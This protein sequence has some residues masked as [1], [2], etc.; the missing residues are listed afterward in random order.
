MAACSISIVVNPGLV[1][2]LYIIVLVEIISWP[3]GILELLK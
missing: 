1:A 2:F 3:C